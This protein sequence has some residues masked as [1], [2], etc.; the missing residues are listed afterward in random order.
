[1]RS[2]SVYF[3]Y[4]NYMHFCQQKALYLT[5]EYWEITKNQKLQTTTKIFIFTCLSTGF[6]KTTGRSVTRHHFFMVAFINKYP[7]YGRHRIS[8]P[9]RIVGPLQISRVCVIYLEKK[10]KKKM[11]RLTRPSVH[12]SKR[13][14][15]HATAPRVGNGR[16]APTPRF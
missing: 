1:M 15:V 6:F 7:A 3:Y 2:Y 5:S 11:G 14:R 16:S 9:M 10:E 12:A 13:P 8:Q 4:T